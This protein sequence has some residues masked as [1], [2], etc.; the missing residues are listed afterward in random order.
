MSSEE[1]D[2]W[3]QNFYGALGPL[4]EIQLNHFFSEIK[5]TTVQAWRFS[6]QDENMAAALPL[7]LHPTS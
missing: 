4:V 5:P 3:V 7:P 2:N 1:R 6:D